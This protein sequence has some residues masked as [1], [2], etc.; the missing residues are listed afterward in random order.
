MINIDNVGSVETLRSIQ[1][2][3]HYSFVFLFKILIFSLHHHFID[4]NPMGFPKFHDLF[5]FKVSIFIS[6]QKSRIGQHV[7]DKRQMARISI[8]IQL[9]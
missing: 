1:I 6:A 4:D 8:D 5:R 3:P 7:K 2:K 9:L